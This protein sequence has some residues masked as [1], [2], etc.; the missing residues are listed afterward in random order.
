VAASGASGGLGALGG[1]GFP[2]GSSSALIGGGGAGG[3]G[4]ETRVGSKKV[5]AVVEKACSRVG[6][7]SS[8]T[9]ATGSSGS[10]ATGSL[11]DCSGDAR[12]IAG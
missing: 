12:A 5:M 3:P 11:Y 8:K 1:T 7:T 4:G 10:T 9:T 6:L 2:R